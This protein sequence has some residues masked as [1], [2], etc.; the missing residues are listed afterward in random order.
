MNSLKKIIVVFLLLVAFFSFI[1]IKVISAETNLKIKNI[2]VIDIL[3]KNRYECRPSSGFLFNVET[4]L[5]KKSRGANTIS[6]NIF[7]IDRTTGASN[8]L[9]SENI[10]VP[11]NK[12]AISLQYKTL[13]SDCK[14]V[15]LNNG[16]KIIGSDRNTPYCFN[17]L[18]QFEAIFRSYKKSKKELLNIKNL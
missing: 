10:L 11:S 14:K 13:K 7:V 18:I 4:N 15:I 17:E 3:T 1:K 8:L 5:V 6:A 12:G 9:A 16:D 2:N